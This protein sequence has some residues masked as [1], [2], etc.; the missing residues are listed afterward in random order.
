MSER[1]L[2]LAD[3]QQGET[4]RILKINAD[5]IVRHRLMDFGLRSGESVTMIRTAPLADPLEFRIRGG[6]ISLR[7]SE[8]GKIDI[9]RME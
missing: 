1:K 6:Y 9:T 4:G 8:A 2:T 3:L 5:R 7:R